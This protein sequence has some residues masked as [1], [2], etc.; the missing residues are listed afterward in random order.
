MKEQTIKI[1]SNYI[2]QLIGYAMQESRS[3]DKILSADAVE[4]VIDSLPIEERKIIDDF[5]MQCISSRSDFVGE[6]YKSGF[7]D[8][9]QVLKAANK[10]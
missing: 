8:C 5:I 4:K 1:L 2:D 7:K 10:I 3:D 6:M 9:L